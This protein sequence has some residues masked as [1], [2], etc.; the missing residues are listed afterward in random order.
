M[1]PYAVVEFYYFQVLRRQSLCSMPY[2]CTCDYGLAGKELFTCSEV[3]PPS[4]VLAT[5][6]PQQPLAKLTLVPRPLMLFVGPGLRFM[7]GR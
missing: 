2:V 3:Q 6:K 1:A 4:V 7:K 5:S